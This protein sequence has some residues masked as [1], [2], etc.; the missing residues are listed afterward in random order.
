M[1]AALQEVFHP[2]RCFLARM[3]ESLPG[4]DDGSSREQK[5]GLSLLPRVTAWPIC[6]TLLRPH[7]PATYERS[8]LF[9]PLSSVSLLSKL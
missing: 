1:A 8:S 5:E 3:N 4:R 2:T 9:Y 6:V 7:V